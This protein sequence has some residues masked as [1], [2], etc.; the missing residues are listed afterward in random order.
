MRNTNAHSAYIIRGGSP[1]VGTIRCLG[2]KNFVTKAMVASILAE[3]PSRLRN[4]PAIGD[5]AI[6]SEM[7]SSI[8]VG[9][10]YDGADEMLIDPSSLDHAHVPV[11]Q[12]G[13]NRVPILL[14]AA[15]LHRFGEVSVPVLGGC[16]IGARG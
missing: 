5:T 10:Q 3:T 14:L 15:L 11:P 2:A 13:S 1:V 16:K 6:T 9:I 12:T 7:L 4:V 8:G